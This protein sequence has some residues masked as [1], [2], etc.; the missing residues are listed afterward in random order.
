MAKAAFSKKQTLFN[1]KLDLNL[2]ETLV[3]CYT[4]SIALYCVETWTLRKVD[5][6]CLES[7]WNVVLEKDKDQFDWSRENVVLTK[8]P[9]RKNILHTTRRRKANWIGHILRRNYLLKR[10]AER[11]IEV[12][13]RPGTRCKQLLDDLKE[14]RRYWKLKEEALDRTLWKTLWTCCKADYGV[15]RGDVKR[16]NKSFS[17]SFF[18]FWVCS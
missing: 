2:T 9:G 1:R 14:T 4:W 3:K 16:E 15:R 7:F 12:T 6:K 8:S 5:D 17:K 18:P 13:E 11:K 10:V